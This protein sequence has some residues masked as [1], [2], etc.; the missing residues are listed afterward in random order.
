MDKRTDP[1]N[2]GEYYVI[3]GA[4][5]MYIRIHG[6]DF[7]VPPA[8]VPI[9]AIKLEQLGYEVRKPR[10]L[11]HENAAAAEYVLKQWYRSVA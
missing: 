10:F 1:W 7:V 5:M 9:R 6:E 2:D 3:N 4:K 8:D 11:R